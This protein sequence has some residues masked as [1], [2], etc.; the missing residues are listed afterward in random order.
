MNRQY[1]KASTKKKW[2]REAVDNPRGLVSSRKKR[3]SRTEENQIR[4]K[5]LHSNSER[6]KSTGIKSKRRKSE[7]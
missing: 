2:C 6:S 1:R 3:K 7:R 4:S 5:N